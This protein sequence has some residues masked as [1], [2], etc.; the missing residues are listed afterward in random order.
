L[1]DCLF[2]PKAANVSTEGLEL[3]CN[4][5]FHYGALWRNE[6]FDSTAQRGVSWWPISVQGK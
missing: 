4:G 2:I 1:C 5:V 3:L 6:P